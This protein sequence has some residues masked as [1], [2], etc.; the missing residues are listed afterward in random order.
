MYKEDKIICD[1]CANPEIVAR[2]S[3][4]FLCQECYDKEEAWVNY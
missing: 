1:Y 4:V 3:H 2:V